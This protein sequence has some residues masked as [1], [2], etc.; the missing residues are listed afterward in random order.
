MNNPE[1][2][3]D[4]MIRRPVVAGLAVSLVI[5]ILD[6]ASKWWILLDIMN[7]PLTI[8]VLPF[9]NLVLVWNRGVSFGLFPA[10]DT[11]GMWI[12]VGVALAVCLALLMWL[13]SA[14][15]RRTVIALG[16]IIGGAI[17]NVVDRIVHGA[18]VD[19]IDVHAGGYH[20]PAF[21]VADS[22][23]CIGAGLLILDSLTSK[24]HNRE[25]EG[26]SGS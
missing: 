18:V 6:Q 16:L 2:Q 22:A 25:D 10:G 1:S 23:I 3:I 8:E 17:G 15:N 20:W 5:L 14:D 19:F 21:N 11:T 7:P 26:S 4:A 12:L 24:P 13:R 9:F